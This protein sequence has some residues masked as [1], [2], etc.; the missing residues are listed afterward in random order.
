MFVVW[1][2]TNSILSTR[3]LP[4]YIHQLG[5]C[6]YWYQGEGIRTNLVIHNILRLTLSLECWNTHLGILLHIVHITLLSAIVNT[7]SMRRWS[8]MLSRVVEGW[9]GVLM[10]VHVRF[11]KW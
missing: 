7:R 9:S 1:V 3:L 5:F 4:L 6:F 10:V 8:S 11:G 2:H